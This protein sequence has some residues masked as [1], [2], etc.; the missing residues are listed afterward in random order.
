MPG[1][2]FVPG[3]SGSFDNTE[4]DDDC[5][6]M[7]DSTSSDQKNKARNNDRVVEH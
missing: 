1:A 4:S 3:I 6:D 2:I 5:N 7:L